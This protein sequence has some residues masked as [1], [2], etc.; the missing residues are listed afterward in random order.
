MKNK[1]HELDESI[2]LEGRSRKEGKS[3][4]TTKSVFQTH[5]KKTR[6]H[7]MLTSG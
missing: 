4:E 1:V 7:F 2:T 3:N 5:V 6:K